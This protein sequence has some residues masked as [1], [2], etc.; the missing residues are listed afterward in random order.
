MHAAPRPWLKEA[1]ICLDSGASTGP[2]LVVDE[3]PEI[4]GLIEIVLREDGLAVQTATSNEEALKKARLT[5]PSLVLLDVGLTPATDEAFVAGLREMYGYRVPIIV[6]S[7]V[8]EPA[9]Q[10]A[11]RR[12]GAVDALH[13]PFDISDL[14]V[15]VQRHVNGIHDSGRSMRRRDDAGIVAHNSRPKRHLAP[16]GKRQAD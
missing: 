8:C 12:T 10:N 7:A 15:A 2:I 6:I 5:R 16:P 1:G 4:T 13:K 9:F 3:S 14:L 11:L